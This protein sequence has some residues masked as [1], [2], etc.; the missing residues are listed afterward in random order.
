SKYGAGNGWQAPGELP[1]QTPVD[2]NNS[3]WFLSNNAQ[4]GTTWDLYGVKAAESL[5]ASAGTLG[6]RLAFE[7]NKQ[8]ASWNGPSLEVLEAAAPGLAASYYEPY[9]ASAPYVASV[10][11]DAS[12]TN[13]YYQSL[14][15][16]WDTENQL[17]RFCVKSYGRLWYFYQMFNEVAG[18][19]CAIVG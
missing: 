5:N 16:G 10:F 17:D 9:G 12:S 18:K 15:D 11:K 7:P 13:G 2:P 14:V 1:N 19:I 4:P 3:D 8:C 6:S